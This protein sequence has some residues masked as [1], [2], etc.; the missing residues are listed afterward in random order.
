MLQFAMNDWS[1]HKQTELWK[2]SKLIQGELFISCLCCVIQSLMPVDNESQGKGKD[3]IAIN[4]PTFF[5]I[6]TVYHKRFT[7]WKR[8]IS[9]SS[10]YTYHWGSRRAF[11]ILFHCLDHC[12]VLKLRVFL[13]IPF[14]KGRCIK[15]LSSPQNTASSLSWLGVSFS[16]LCWKVIVEEGFA[17][18]VFERQTMVESET[19]PDWSSGA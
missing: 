18:R 15:S 14:W 3:H 16:Y 17:C 4:Q 19:V 13:G 9:V 12:G 1:V 8:R 10:I 6:T 5:F 11:D 7:K 2:L